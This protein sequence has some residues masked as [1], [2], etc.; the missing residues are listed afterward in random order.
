MKQTLIVVSICSVILGCG[1]SDVADDIPDEQSTAPV[2]EAAPFATHP[3]GQPVVL[4]RAS[5]DPTISESERPATADALVSEFE[6]DS[7]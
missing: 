1:H 2:V 7:R 5:F 4:S 6:N 3:K